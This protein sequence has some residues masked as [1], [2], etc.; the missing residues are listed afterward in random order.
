MLRNV[1]SNWL[2]LAVTIVATYFLVPFNLH[3][4]GQQTYGFW[5]IITALTGYLSLLQLGVPMASVRHIAGAIAR[6]DSEDLNRVVVSCVALYLG[7]GL[8]VALAGFGVLRVFETTYD[9]PAAIVPEAHG[10]LALTIAN[11]AIGFLGQMPYAILS[12]YQQFVFKNAILIMVVLLR[13]GLSVI[14]LLWSPSILM[15]AVAQLAVSVLELVILWPLVMFLH[16]EIRPNPRFLSMKTVLAISGFSIFVCLLSMGF[17]LSFQTDALVIGHYLGAD[18]VPLFGVANSL[19]LYLMQFVVGI[20]SVVMPV[21]TNLHEQ[22]R[23]GELQA[24]FYKWSKIALAL[25]WCAAAFLLVFGPDFLGIWVGGSFEEAGGRVLRILMV[26]YLFFLPM[27][28]VAMPILMGIGKPVHATL[29]VLVAGLANLVLSVALVGPLGL[30]G[31]AWGTTIPNLGLSAAFTVLICRELDIPIGAY[32]TEVLPR[33]LLG[34]AI[35]LAALLGLRSLWQPAGLASLGV[36]GLV[37]VLFFAFV[38]YA[39]VLRNDRHVALPNPLQMIP[40]HIPWLSQ[41]TRLS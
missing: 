9:I 20:A 11:L 27:R 10:A 41:L 5:L 13:T 32:L 26:S 12:S 14:L 17:Q 28:G 29:A 7:L 33:S 37:T 1:G 39:L 22:K 18:H 19:L 4:L 31:V 30:D 2:L 16:P 24:V 25:V 3:V 40:A 34:F 15:L 6:N 36:A 21:A 23:K 35:V 8:V 38:W